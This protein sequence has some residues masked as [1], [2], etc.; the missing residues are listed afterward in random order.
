M[1]IGMY[2]PMTVDEQGHC[3]R[4]RYIEHD[5]QQRGLMGSY[6][7]ENGSMINISCGTRES[8]RTTSRSTFSNAAAKVA[9]QSRVRMPPCGLEPFAIVTS[10]SHRRELLSSS[11]PPSSPQD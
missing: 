11:R 5:E 7:H 8:F 2:I 1:A 6:A 3:V 4:V 10:V 9:A